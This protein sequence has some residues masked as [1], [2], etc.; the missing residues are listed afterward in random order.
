MGSRILTL[1]RQAA[2]LGRLRT[3]FYESGRPQRSETWILTSHEQDY[4]KAAAELWGGDVHEWKPLNAN[5]K[6]WRLVTKARTIDALLPPGD[7]L[8]QYNE[9]WSGG[10]CQRRCDGVTEQ[11][12]KRPCICLAQ[13]GPEWYLLKKGTVCSATTRLNVLLPEMPDLGVWRAETK[14]FYAADG[15]AGQVDTVLQGTGG[16]GVVPVRLSIQQRQVVRAGQ[17]KKF[18]VVMV[19]PRLAKLRHALSGPMSMAAA[20]DPHAVERVAIEAP[21]PDY[22]SDA[23]SALTAD[24]LNDIWRKADTRGELTPELKALLSARSEELKAETVRRP[25]PQVAAEPD[26]DGAIDAE[27]LDDEPADEWTRVWSEIG[28]AARA[29]GWSK[30]RTEEQFAEFSGGTMVGSA[31]TNELRSF[32]EHL[33]GVR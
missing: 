28:A 9:M 12:A 33:R 8:S 19:V 29:R 5:I 11:L 25:R 18:P 27:V 2:E 14:S 30:D 10:G 7:P 1:Q 26:E 15:L 24:D 22:A 3:G 23:A 4:L 20:L 21:R 17:T 32:L 6:Q 31:D 13:H 16:Q